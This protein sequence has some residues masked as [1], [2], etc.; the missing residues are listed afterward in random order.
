MKT[1]PSASRDVIPPYTLHDLFAYFEHGIPGGDFLMS[2][3]TNNLFGA[4]G[5]GDV[6]N[7]SRIAPI[8]TFL[9]SYA[10]QMAFGDETKVREWLALHR[11]LKIIETEKV[12]FFIAS[13]VTGTYL[14]SAPLGTPFVDVTKAAMDNFGQ[15]LV[16][17]RTAGPTPL[18]ELYALPSKVKRLVYDPKKVGLSQENR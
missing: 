18:S 5:H 9:H 3:L 8:C 13:S 16:E 11:W 4:I 14:I 10:P 1:K 6:E 12:D 7:V 15:A 2:V 17:L